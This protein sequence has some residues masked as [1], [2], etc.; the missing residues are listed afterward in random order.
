M[1]EL[2]N[3]EDLIAFR[4]IIFALQRFLLPYAGGLIL[5]SMLRYAWLEFFEKNEDDREGDA[6]RWF[7]ATG[8]KMLLPL[9]V[10]IAFPFLCLEPAI[11]FSD[12]YT[13]LGNI[14]V[15][16]VSANNKI[17]GYKQ[18]MLREGYL[19]GN[20]IKQFDASSLGQK[21]SVVKIWMVEK[22]SKEVVMKN[23]VTDIEST[24]KV[25]KNEYGFWDIITDLDV[26]SAI[27]YILVY[28]LN[29]IRDG[30]EY[31][32]GVVFQFLLYLDLILGMFAMLMAFI[33]D[34]RGNIL[35]WFLEN[36][37]LQLWS[38]VFLAV[39]WVLSYVMYSKM[40]STEA[41]SVADW[42]MPLVSILAFTFIGVFA[43]K[44]VMGRQAAGSQMM[45]TGGKMA[46]NAIPMVG[47]IV[48]TGLSS[49]MKGLASSK[50]GQDAGGLIKKILSG[51]YGSQKKAEGVSGLGNFD[52]NS[53]RIG[54]VRSAIANGVSSAYD[55]FKPQNQPSP[56]E[57][58]VDSLSDLNNKFGTNE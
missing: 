1:K 44:L 54:S 28:V 56:M 27:F 20:T 33:P 15:G 6:G 11:Y 52:A 9:A 32:F 17:E 47:G 51:N 46:L 36:I 31:A 45:Q 48:A 57:K 39:E 25:S 18:Q 30:I 10:F 40:L 55:Y 24:L 50:F 38:V 4:E 58:M 41:S 43:A 3:V 5:L 7:V 16:E 37:A 42:V 26:S 8:K 19:N 29:M 2:Y 23:T 21:V 53:N 13:K 34:L 12:L 14:E 49:N 35:N 22:D